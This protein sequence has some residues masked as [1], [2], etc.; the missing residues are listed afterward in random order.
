MIGAYGNFIINDMH[1]PDSTRKNYFDLLRRSCKDEDKKVKPRTR[2][3][4][5]TEPNLEKVRQLYNFRSP[6][7]LNKISLYLF[8]EFGKPTMLSRKYLG[9][10]DKHFHRVSNG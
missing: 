9:R 8:L 6:L 1:M 7:F 4:L 10:F 3:R 2:V 5:E